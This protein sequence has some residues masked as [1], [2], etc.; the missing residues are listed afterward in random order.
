PAP[1]RLADVVRG[2]GRC[3]RPAVA[4]P[5]GGEAAGERPRRPQPAGERSL[6][7]SAAPLHPGRAVPLRV[8]APRRRPQGLVAAHTP[9]TVPSAALGRQ[10]VA[11]SVSPRERLVTGLSYRREPNVSPKVRR[12]K[13]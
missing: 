4:H 11:E 13:P 5:P 3:R 12:R 8:H 1:P 9:R 7:G 6:S 10:P 2:D